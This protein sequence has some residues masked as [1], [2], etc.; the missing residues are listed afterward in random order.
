MKHEAAS[1]LTKQAF[2]DALKKKL[3]TKK[4]SKITV[5]E[6]IEECGLNRKTFY[7]H[8]RDIDDLIKWSLQQEFT[9]LVKQFDTMSEIKD[10][11]YCVIDHIKRNH[12]ICQYVLNAEGYLNI[13]EFLFHEFKKLVIVAIDKYS[14]NTVLSADYKEFLIDFYTEALSSILIS[15][16]TKDLNIP[17]ATLEKKVN[18][19]DEYLKKTLFYIFNDSNI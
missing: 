13:K 8:F 15:Y 4:F 9:E 11:I 18:Y 6:L 7:Y 2:A 1:R 16:I 19:L 3:K 10:M 14:K 5:T 12:Y 17:E